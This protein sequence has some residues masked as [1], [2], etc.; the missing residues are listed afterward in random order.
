[1]KRLLQ[2]CL[3]VCFSI[4]M[5]SM[6]LAQTV[7]CKTI[8]SGEITDPL[9]EVITNGKDQWGYNF[10][11]RRFTGSYCKSLYDK[12]FYCQISPDDT[13][14]VMK[15]NKEFLSNE[16]C[17]DDGKLDRPTDF[18]GSYKGS[19]AWFINHRYGQVYMDGKYYQTEYFTKAVA[20]PED[21]YSQMDYTVTPPTLNWYTA[22]GEL[23][24]KA[25][26]LRLG[27]GPS[28]FTKDFYMAQEIYNFKPM[29]WHGVI[30]TA[31]VG[32]GLGH[33]E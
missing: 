32:P 24:G 10:E 15:W 21:A 29:D 27:D 5:T 23:L 12:P 28:N 6:A 14:L 22:E 18:G 33:V 19:G 2:F 4:A 17:N 8:Q 1:M 16:D 7:T 9:G 31:P 11:A 30:Y 13:D 20:V 3:I 25:V 26:F